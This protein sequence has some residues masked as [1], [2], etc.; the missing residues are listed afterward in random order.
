MPGRTLDVNFERKAA[1]DL[2]RLEPNTFF[3]I[4]ACVVFA[5]RMGENAVSTALVGTVE[6]WQ[7]TAGAN[8]VKRISRGIA[9]TSGGGVSPY[10]SYARRG[11]DVFPRCLFMINET[12]NAAL[13]QAGQT[14]TV[15]PRRGSQ[16]KSPW[17]DLDLTAIT[18]QTIE[19][20]HLYDVHLGE[21]VV[22]YVTLEPLQAVL[23]VKRGEYQIPAA[24]TDKPGNIR[25]GGLDRRMRGRWQ[26]VSQMW[27][28]NKGSRSKLTLLGNLDYLH[29]LSTQLTWQQGNAARSVRVMY[30]EAGQ[31]T[32]AIVIDD[33]TIVDTTCYW[34]PCKDMNEANYLLSI[35]NSDTLYDAVQPLMPKGQFGARHVHKHLWKLPIP[36]FDAANTLHAR[37]SEAGA[38]AAAGAAERLEELRV[39]RGDKLTVTIARRELRKWLRQSPEGTAVEEAVRDLLG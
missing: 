29:K 27:D 12:K 39:E 23:P 18:E 28:D 31:P 6:G 5:E 3:P 26:T 8:D 16:D 1:W 37:V 32:A 15:N 10:D 19:R 24:D 30:S 20:S 36:E 21:T 7:G 11:A 14:V 38:Q 17:R 9:D 35:I 2:E 22:P 34:I 33:D 25:L 13:V 4:T